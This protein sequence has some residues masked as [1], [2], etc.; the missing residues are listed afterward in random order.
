M[1]TNRDPRNAE[2]LWIEKYRAA[3][4][5]VPVPRTRIEKMRALVDTTWHAVILQFG[6]LTAVSSRGNR[7]DTQLF[8]VPTEKGSQGEKLKKPTVQNPAL[9]KAS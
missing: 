6:A 7:G 8:A 4:Y 5:E 3:L 2:D 1:E 9:P